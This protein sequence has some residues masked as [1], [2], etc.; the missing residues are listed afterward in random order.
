MEDRQLTPEKAYVIIIIV[1]GFCVFV[2][3]MLIFN[4]DPISK[5][6]LSKPEL[7][8]ATVI[9]GILAAI[10]GILAA[11]CTAIFFSFTYEDVGE[12]EHIS[13]QIMSWFLIIA[14]GILVFL[15]LYCLL[16]I[17]AFVNMRWAMYVVFLATILIICGLVL[18]ERWDA[19]MLTRMICPFCKSRISWEATKCPKCTSDL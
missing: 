8:H 16:K 19:T 3:T 14:F 2:A 5:S 17:G 18:I 11:G 4:V 10:F 12:Q 1:F 9:F 7:E 13:V 15:C 6:K